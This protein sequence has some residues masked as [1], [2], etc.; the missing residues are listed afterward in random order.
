[1]K[2][3]RYISYIRNR[4]IILCA[5]LV[6]VCVSFGVSYSNFVYNSKEHRAVEMFVNK[7]NY[8]LKINNNDSS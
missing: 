1:M 8:V 5:A 4:I 3:D 7:L 6:I 2:S